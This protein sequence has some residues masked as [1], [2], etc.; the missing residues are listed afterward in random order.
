MGPEECP[1][2][3]VVGVR[4]SVFFFNVLKPIEICSG[5]LEFSVISQESAIERHPL[6]GVPLCSRK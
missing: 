6:S 2:Y 5:H 4:S 3:E 1:L